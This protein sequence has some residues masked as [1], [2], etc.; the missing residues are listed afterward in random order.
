M[1]VNIF[2]RFKNLP[3]GLANKDAFF[4]RIGMETSN[5][6]RWSFWFL[7]VVALALICSVANAQEFDQDPNSPSPVILTQADSTRALAVP[8]QRLGRL[9][10][11]KIPEQAFP[12]DGQVVIFV[13][14]LSLMDGEA[15][16]A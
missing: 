13:T 15:A 14:A 6:R 10:L 4:R 7:P 11:N 16:N 8:A 5:S 3:R 2:K 1:L 12:A 9:N